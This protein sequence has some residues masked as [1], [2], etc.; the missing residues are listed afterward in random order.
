M[1]TV[2]AE[3]SA[4]ERLRDI[5]QREVEARRN[6]LGYQK[7][8]VKLALLGYL[9]P[10]LF[11]AACIGLVALLGYFVVFQWGSGGF[12]FIKVALL[13]GAV[14]LVV[15]RSMWVRLEEPNGFQATRENAP[16]LFSL[17]DQ[18]RKETNGP[19]VSRVLLDDQLNA[20][21]Q[22][23]PRFG[24]FGGYKN[25]LTIGL[26]LLNALSV[27]QFQAVLAHEYGHL[28]GSHGKTG[29]WIYRSRSIWERLRAEIQI[30]N[31][32]PYFPLGWF[33]ERYVPYFDRASFPLARAN[34]YE[35][36]KVAAEVTDKDAI[37]Q[38][39]VRIHLASIYLDQKFWP[40]IN[41]RAI[42]HSQ[43]DINPLQ[44]ISQSFAELPSWKDNN[45]WLQFCV[46]EETNYVDTHP[47]LSDR[48]SALGVAPQLPEGN[49]EPAV[50]LLGLLELKAR[51]FFDE[52]WQNNAAEDWQARHEQAQKNLQ[53]LRELDQKEK[54][55]SL[56][57]G[58][59][60]LRARLA[61][62]LALDEKAEGILNS[63]VRKYPSDAD[64]LFEL[65]RL[66]AAKDD[67]SCIPLLQKSGELKPVFELPANQIAY[68]FYA[69]RGETENAKPFAVQAEEQALKHQE[70][71]DELSTLK[72]ADEVHQPSL[73][74]ETERKLKEFLQKIN[75]VKAAYVVKKE[76]T[77]FDNA[78][79]HHLIVR[80]KYEQQFNY[81]DF[82]LDLQALNLDEEIYIRFS[83]DT[84]RWLLK[85]AKRV[86][87]SEFFK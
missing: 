81:Q 33:L 58:D 25:Y 24:V 84:D 26:P 66:L 2:T 42:Y 65:G 62:D 47:A 87:G 73:Q 28:S 5:K 17:I 7:K 75:G 37:G 78:Y 72:P 79:S 76:S 1:S 10:V 13:V 19:P 69:S 36:D 38:A 57:A 16:N 15:A 32:V 80:P 29:A 12:L 55:E 21:I 41:E 27:R 3:S 71:Y 68:H 67:I 40:E 85:L 63:H 70:A 34:E 23:I 22:Q 74:P 9:A 56:S 82:V 48:L 39:L 6:P 14:I 20:S 86:D 18:T 30:N 51:K 53:S 43:P 83:V 52:R 50:T 45:K 44:K 64:G 11:I 49:T 31:S 35:A 77:V 46:R 54:T 4:D 59:S 60:M 61:I 8:V